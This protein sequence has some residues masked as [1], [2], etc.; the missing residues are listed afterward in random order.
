MRALGLLEETRFS[1]IQLLM[2]AATETRTQK[3]KGS[4][5]CNH[6]A[7]AIAKVQLPVFC[8][9]L[10][11]WAPSEGGLFAPSSFIFGHAGILGL[12]LNFPQDLG[13][14]QDCTEG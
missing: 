6:S 14:P 9:S 4:G 10:V 8:T 2:T 12:Q 1:C 13:T 3:E 5:W 7:D 11:A